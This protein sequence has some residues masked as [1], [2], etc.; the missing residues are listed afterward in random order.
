MFIAKVN[1]FPAC[2]ILQVLG[3]VAVPKILPSSK[4]P[5]SW[6]NN[7]TKTIEELKKI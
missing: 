3:S 1:E 4:R 2:N 6:I 5:T 7:P